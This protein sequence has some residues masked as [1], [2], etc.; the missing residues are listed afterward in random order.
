M[1]S[2]CGDLSVE[3]F[4]KKVKLQ[5]KRLG[6]RINEEKLINFSVKSMENRK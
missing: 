1:R 4:I 5:V 3:K 6:A 2:T